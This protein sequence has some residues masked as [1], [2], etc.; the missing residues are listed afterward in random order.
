MGKRRSL[1]TKIVVVATDSTGNAATERRS[2]TLK[3]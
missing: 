2:I 1:K 3:R